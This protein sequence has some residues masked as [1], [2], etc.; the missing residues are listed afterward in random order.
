MIEY[1]AVARPRKHDAA[2][3]GVGQYMSLFETTPPPA[4]TPFVPPAER[5]VQMKEKLQELHTEKNELL[6]SSW[7]PATNPKATEYVNLIH[8]VHLPAFVRADLMIFSF[9]LL[10]SPEMRI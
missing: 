4:P 10:P 1:K 3:T 8:F 9:S 6:A 7:D 5:K 2:Y